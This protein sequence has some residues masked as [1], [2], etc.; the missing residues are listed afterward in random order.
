MT[1]FLF[2]FAVL[3]WTVGFFAHLFSIGNVDVSVYVPYVWLLHLGLFIVWIPTVRIMDKNMEFKAERQTGMPFIFDP[4]G[5]FRVHFKQVPI[6]LTIIAIAGLF[7]AIV[8][9]LVLFGSYQGAADVKDGQYVLHNH[10]YVIRNMT[11]LEYD[12]YK[13]NE[14]RFFSAIWLAF[15]GF[16]IAVLFPFQKLKVKEKPT[17]KE[18]PSN[19][20]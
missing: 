16:A 9:L 12:Q 4:F 8:N 1:K 2:W 7:Y 20:C 15:Y 6:W 13:A 5:F 10:G 11:K 19:A 3:G 18:L 14:M 17:N